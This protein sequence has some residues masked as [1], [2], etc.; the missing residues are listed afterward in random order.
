MQTYVFTLLEKE[1]IILLLTR[2]QVCTF[3]EHSEC[4]QAEISIHVKRKSAAQKFLFLN[5]VIVTW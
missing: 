4:E 3:R 1:L 5:K 2:R